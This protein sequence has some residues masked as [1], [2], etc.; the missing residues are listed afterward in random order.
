MDVIRDRPRG[1]DLC[2][3]VDDEDLM[4]VEI[5][6]YPDDYVFVGFTPETVVARDQTYAVASTNDVN[7]R[8]NG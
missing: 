4:F 7:A 6:N 1:V 5:L 8:R 3:S 2:G